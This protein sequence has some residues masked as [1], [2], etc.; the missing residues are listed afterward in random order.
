MTVD[1]VSDYEK[2]TWDWRDLIKQNCPA[3]HSLR[4]Q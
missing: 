1:S 3:L 4:T 2:Q